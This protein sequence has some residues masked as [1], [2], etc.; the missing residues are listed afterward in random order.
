MGGYALGN[1]QFHNLLAQH[2]RSQ[3]VIGH[4]QMSGPGIRQPSLDHLTMHQAVVHTKPH[5]SVARFVAGF[6]PQHTAGHNNALG[7]GLA[8]K[9]GQFIQ[10]FVT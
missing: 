1:S 2:I 10:L 6:V 7:P 5:I 4:N 3:F 9:L 8:G